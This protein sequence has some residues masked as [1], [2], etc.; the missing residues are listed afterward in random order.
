MDTFTYGDIKNKNYRQARVLSLG[1]YYHACFLYEGKKGLSWVE[2]TAQRL[3]DLGF[4]VFYT[5][6]DAI[7]GHDIFQGHLRSFRKSSKIVVVI[8]KD[9][10][11]NGYCCFLLNHA[12]HEILYR[13]DGTVSSC[14]IIP[15]VIEP[16]T[17]ILSVLKGFIHLTCFDEEFDWFNKLVHSLE[18]T[19]S[20][21]VKYSD[22]K[23]TY[24]GRIFRAAEELSNALR[25]AGDSELYSFLTK[26][27]AVEL[28]HFLC[29]SDRM[30]CFHVAMRTVGVE[31]S[32]DCVTFSLS[33]FK[34]FAA[35]PY[36]I[37][38][39][40][41]ENCLKLK[42]KPSKLQLSIRKKSDILNRGKAEDIQHFNKKT[43]DILRIPNAPLWSIMYKFEGITW[44]KE[45][46]ELCRSLVND[47]V[48]EKAP[49]EIVHPEFSNISARVSS[50]EHLSDDSKPTKDELAEAGYFF[51]K[52]CNV[53]RCFT[54]DGVSWD[55]KQDEN[56]WKRHAKW[57][58]NCPYVNS[59]KSKQ[60]ISKSRFEERRFT[61]YNEKYAK[62]C[63]RLLTFQTW[64]H[65]EFPYSTLA[66][67][68]LYYT[69]FEDK[70]TCFM[71]G[72]G[73]RH[74]NRDDDP[75]HRHALSSPDC[76]FVRMKK[77]DDFIAQIKQEREREQ[78]YRDDELVITYSI[79]IRKQK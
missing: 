33:I 2:Q 53:Y 50:M 8:D 21:L 78:S 9:F 15:V 34:N 47:A 62:L 49:S 23:F 6:R 29:Q 52:S 61:V 64:Q 30:R 76:S 79:G 43:Q 77:S 54:C 66:D 42:G 13:D 17:D 18:S 1:K 57:Y 39:I 59:Q 19:S 60:F 24:N 51:D 55:F 25:E 22:D 73:F 58:Y 27:I 56:P 14:E 38:E 63:D 74:W 31:V 11:Q 4:I 71:C 41:N 3:E 16:C 36:L 69:G 5:D 44:S 45:V 10:Q 67:A 75:W 26:P 72:H 65:V 35:K 40:F 32:D 37:S 12:L 48:V 20:A 46:I 28:T 70:V 7:P 68:G